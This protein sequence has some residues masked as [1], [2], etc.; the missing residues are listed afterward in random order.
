MS[1]W[2]V[3][4]HEFQEKAL[5]ELNK[6]SWA[7]KATNAQLKAGAKKIAQQVISIERKYVKTGTVN[8]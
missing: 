1:E 3:E 8:S 6:T 5:R 4:K 7:F 2:Q